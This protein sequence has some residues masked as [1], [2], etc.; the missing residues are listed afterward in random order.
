MNLLL[1]II[2][3]SVAIGLISVLRKPI[4]N[5]IQDIFVFIAV[6]MNRALWKVAPKI[7]RDISTGIMDTLFNNTRVW[8]EIINKYME[9]TFP[10][11]K[12]YKAEELI[13]P[14]LAVNSAVDRLARGLY[15]KIIDAI[16]PETKITPEKALDNVAA[17]FR[18]NL[19]FQMSAWLLHWISD[20]FSLGSMKSFKDLPNAISWSFGLGWLSWLVMGT[21]FRKAISDP[22]EVYYNRIYQTNIPTLSQYL[23]YAFFTRKSLDEIKEKLKDYGYDPTNAAIVISAHQKKLSETD[24]EKLFKYGL[25]DENKYKELL[26]GRGYNQYHIPLLVELTKTEEVYKHLHDTLEVLIDLY[27]SG[28]VTYDEVT[29]VANQIGVDKR[30]L[31]AMIT[32]KKWKRIR[33]NTLS[34]SEVLSAFT[35]GLLDENQTRDY[36]RLLGYFDDDIDILLALQ[37]KTLSVSQI[38]DAVLRGLLTYEEA[39]KKIMQL[40]YSPDDADLLLSLRVIPVTIGQIIDAFINGYISITQIIDVLKAFGYTEDEAYMLLFSNITPTT[41]N[42][43][44]K[45]YKL[46]I[47]SEQ[48]LRDRL[49]F[50]GIPEEEINSLFST[51]GRRL[52]LWQLRDMFNAKAIHRS[53]AYEKLL[54]L[55]YDEITA[56]ALLDTYF[57]PFEIWEYDPET[58]QLK[59]TGQYWE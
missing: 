42:R 41:I 38:Q 28:K 8:A 37:K 50:I 7:A 16:A 47:I 39:K 26:Q 54:E 9:L 5:L 3:S 35:R 14:D 29:A 34:K 31:D 55:G 12:G 51:G 44:W 32:H 24:I 11:V 1:W 22:L 40:G 21:P 2:G 4:I 57:K 6:T 52:T 58:K 17:F 59:P 27:L 56:K 23:E 25:I 10:D 19:S 43:M 30:E 18:A 45:M 13:T 53:E 46:G 15:K 20:T 33:D 49:Q 36:L 48:E